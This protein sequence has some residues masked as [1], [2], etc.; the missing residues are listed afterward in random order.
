MCLTV[1]DSI[2]ILLPK[3]FYLQMFAVISC[4][5]GF[6]AYLSFASLSIM[7][8]HPSPL[9]YLVVL[10]CLGDPP[11]L[12]LQDQPHHKLHQFLDR[13]DAGLG[14]FKALYL[15]LG[16]VGIPLTLL[17]P[18]YQGQLFAQARGR[19]SSPA[20]TPPRAPSLT[21]MR[22]GPV[23]LCCLGDVQ[24][25]LFGLL[26]WEKG[27]PAHPLKFSGPTLPHFPGKV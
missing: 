26:Q 25:L 18:C 21:P 3:Q 20:L 14:Q 5:S 23:L 7:Y 1:V 9:P 8:P 22:S 27:W 24:G 10:L 17:I 13:V 6:K 15:G 11:I 2:F 4:W 16:G 19:D 12:L